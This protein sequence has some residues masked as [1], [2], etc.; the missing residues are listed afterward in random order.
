M[1]II[2]SLQESL[3][4]EKP[5]I[6]TLGNYDGVH[7][8]HQAILKK[9]TGLAHK[10]HGK[11]LVITFKNHPSSILNPSLPSLQICSFDHKIHLL[12]QAGIDLVVVLEFTREFA[13]QTPEEFLQKMLLAIPFKNLI[14][15]H[16]AVLGKGRTG[17]QAEIER[18]SQKLNFTVE[19]LPQLTMEDII[20]SSSKIR[21][22]LQQGDLLFVEKLLGRKFSMYGKVISGM[23]KGRVIGFPTL[24]F[25]TKGLCLP[26]LGVYAVKVKSESELLLG[27]ANLGVAPTVRED[28]EPLLEVHLL[29][30]KEDLEGESLEVI[31]HQYIRPE[32][33]F[34][35]LE[36]L[37][38]QIARDVG[39]AK[40]LFQ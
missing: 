34:P 17:N 4:A 5:I 14:L 15:G 33:K 6:A 16:D 22:Y 25:A 23:K 27:V 9:V 2:S 10:E 32:L 28:S 38:E 37:K 13:K 3:D 31:F 39:T 20:V 1:K 21:Q 35:S 12:E 40:N 26:P 11:S 18:L 7:L 19:Y 8:G 24:N 36:A 29:D 30:C